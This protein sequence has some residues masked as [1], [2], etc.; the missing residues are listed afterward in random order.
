[1]HFRKQ[2]QQFNTPPNFISMTSPK[3][4][5]RN[6][7]MKKVPNIHRIW[8][9]SPSPNFDTSPQ[10]SF[11]VSAT[12][13]DSVTIVTRL[14]LT[15]PKFKVEVLSPRALESQFASRIRLRNHHKT[16]RIRYRSLQK[17]SPKLSFTPKSKLC[18]CLHLE[19]N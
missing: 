16:S 3:F 2:K 6:S 18:H 5:F 12:I 19:L 14:K 10:P 9:A 13:L 1:M 8:D 17:V 15:P 4:G 7:K 11:Q